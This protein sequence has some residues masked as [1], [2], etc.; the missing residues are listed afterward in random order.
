MIEC[1]YICKEENMYVIKFKYKLDGR[2]Y[3]I[4]KYYEN[5]LEALVHAVISRRFI[6]AR[7]FD[8]NIIR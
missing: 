6:R 5:R 3:H 8:V 1:W 4:S 2:F 7:G